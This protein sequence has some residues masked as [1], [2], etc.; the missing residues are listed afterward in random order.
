MTDIRK[1]RARDPVATREAILEAARALLAKDG[2]D[3][4][5]LSE[6]AHLAGV[7]RGTAYQHFETR[8][9]LIEATA[10]WVSERMFRSVFGDPD[11]IGERRV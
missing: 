6:V 9:K 4:V 7:N 8:E 2:P 10:D 11:T 1:R 5:S 3:G